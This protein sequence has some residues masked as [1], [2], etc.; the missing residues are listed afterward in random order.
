[1][2]S[3]LVNAFEKAKRGAEAGDA[4]GKSK[5]GVFYMMMG[6]GTKADYKQAMYWITKVA[7]TGNAAAMDTVGIGYMSGIGYPKNYKKML[8]WFIKAAGKG[9]T[10]AMYSLSVCYQDGSGCDKDMEQALF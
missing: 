6:A 8:E 3:E 2:S 4:E 1:M 10:H 9:N 7:E 5:L